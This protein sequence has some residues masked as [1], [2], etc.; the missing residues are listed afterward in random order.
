ML[1]HKKTCVIP[2]FS[3]VLENNCSK[4]SK[5]STE[6]ACSTLLVRPC[7]VMYVLDNKH[8]VC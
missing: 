2:I 7:L 4:K 6:E 1:I 8:F 3:S 5:S